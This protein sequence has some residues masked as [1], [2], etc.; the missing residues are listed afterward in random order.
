MWFFFVL[1][2]INCFLCY[3]CFV[4]VVFC[5]TPLK[6]VFDG[7]NRGFFRGVEYMKLVVVA[8]RDSAVDAFMRPFTVQSVGQAIRSFADEAVNKDSEI[9]KHARDY[10]LFALAM[11]DEDTGRFDNGDSPRSL[12]RAV[13]FKEGDIR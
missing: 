5:F 2:D 4:N 12:A 11:F 6:A 1:V 9:C 3:N 10:E 7:A 8:V 13:D